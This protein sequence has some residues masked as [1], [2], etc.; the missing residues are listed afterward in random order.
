MT[1][2]NH[3]RQR[4]K[5]E[6]KRGGERDDMGPIS[7]SVLPYEE[8]RRGSHGSIKSTSEVVT[9]SINKYCHI[10]VVIREIQILDGKKEAVHKDCPH[11]KNLN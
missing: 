7:F 8:P 5:N 9:P 6:A 11:K 4:T 3:K 1:I 2:N 10:N